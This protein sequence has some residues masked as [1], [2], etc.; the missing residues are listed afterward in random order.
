MFYIALAIYTIFIG[1]YILFSVALLYH[2]QRYAS[3]AGPAP[4]L[5]KMYIL[6]S[7]ALIIL[8]AYFFFRVPWD[9]ITTPYNL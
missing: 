7:L 5:T 6:A 2:V 3:E 8:S 1:A 4:R 9:L